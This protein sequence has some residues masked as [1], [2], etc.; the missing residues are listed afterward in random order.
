MARERHGAGGDRLV[1]KDVVEL[2]TRHG[3]GVIG[4]GQP[5]KTR[6]AHPP[7][8]GSDHHHFADR[9]A[10][11]HGDA[12]VVEDLHAAGTN[13]VAAGLVAREGG[14]VDQSDPRPATG[15][16]EGSNA[17]GGS[18]ADDQDVEAIIAH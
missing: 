1:A 14:L 13:E 17:S 4:V 2:S 15:E 6:Q 7:P 8:G 9:E 18:S 11:R 3:H 16:D 12:E 5:R 10:A